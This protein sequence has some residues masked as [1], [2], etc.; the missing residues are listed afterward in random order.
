MDPGCANTSHYSACIVFSSLNLTTCHYVINRLV[1][2]CLQATVVA[3]KTASMN[4][5]VEIDKFRSKLAM[6]VGMPAT[7]Q[8]V[9][10]RLCRIQRAGRLWC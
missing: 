6:L 5:N 10:G 3:L 2:F 8:L 7:A 1:A 9:M 4:Q